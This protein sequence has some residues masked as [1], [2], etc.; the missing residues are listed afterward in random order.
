MEIPLGLEDKKTDTVCKLNKELKQRVW[1][2]TIKKQLEKLDYS[3][4]D[5]SP[6]IFIYNKDEVYMTIYVDDIL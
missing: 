6:C 3:E 2:V 4:M 5:S 1:H